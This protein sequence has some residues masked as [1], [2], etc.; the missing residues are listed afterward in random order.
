MLVFIRLK[1]ISF[2]IMDFFW[3]NGELCLQAEVFKISEGSSHR[4][5]ETAELT[6]ARTD[7][8]PHIVYPH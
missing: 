5:R 8:T 6:N 2:G 1:C 4:K 3:L 7:T